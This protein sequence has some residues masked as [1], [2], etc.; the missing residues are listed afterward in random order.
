M[1][2]KSIIKNARISS[3]KIKPLLDKIRG[4]EVNTAL[5]IINFSKKKNAK[6]LKKLLKS[7]VANAKNNNLQTENLY[8]C[9]IYTTKGTSLKRLN[10]RARGRSDR[11]TKENAHI[12]IFIKE[13]N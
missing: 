1:I 11:I 5:N 6:I 7:A 13:R 2:V 10:I 9:S 3:Q 4:T 8:I 12:F